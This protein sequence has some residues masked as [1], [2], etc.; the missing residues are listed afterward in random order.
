MEWGEGSLGFDKNV[1][2]V[3][4]HRVVS[5]GPKGAGQDSRSN[6][7]PESCLLTMP[8]SGVFLFNIPVEWGEGPL[9]FDKNVRNVFEHRVVSDGPKGAGQDARSNPFPESCLLTM[10]TSGVF[11][12]NI[13][14]E[15]VTEY[16]GFDQ[17][18][19]S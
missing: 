4:E 5:D 12:F 18:S 10:P 8:T 6:P 9:G 1:R 13:P 15:W 2:N 11:L 17:F 19:G 16:L 14:V 7:F 3:F